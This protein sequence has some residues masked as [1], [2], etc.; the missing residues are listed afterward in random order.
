MRAFTRAALA[1]TAVVALSGGLLQQAVAADVDD[2]TVRVR[3][4]RDSDSNG[5]WDRLKEI[6]VSSITVELTDVD[7]NVRTARTGPDGVAV[8]PPS[9]NLFEGKYYVRLRL[10]NGTFLHD[11]FAATGGLAAQGTIVDVRD[12]EDAEITMGVWNPAD[13]CQD[14]PELSTPCQVAANKDGDVRTTVRFPFS[15]RGDSTSQNN[16]T[17]LATRDDTGNTY[18]LAY[19]REQRRIFA[20]AYAK[21]HTV[22][23]P[24]GTGG[25]YVTPRAG[26]ATTL[27]ATVPNAGNTAH[28]DPVRFDGEFVAAVGKESLGDIEI[29]EDNKEL[30]VVNLNDRQLYTY[31]AD[32]PTATA[33]IDVVP[34]PNPGCRAAGDWRPFGLGVRDGVVYVGGVCSGESTQN[35]ADMEAVVWT[36]SPQTNTFGASPVLRKILN[37]P[38]GQASSA[39]PGSNV[40]NPWL[41]NASAFPQQIVSRPEPM[42]SD[43]E[44]ESNGD[45]ILGFRDRFADMTG[46]E[47]PHPNPAFQGRL[48]TTHSG[49]D[50]NRAC[51][52]AN[53][54]FDW[55]GTGNC[56]NNAPTQPNGGQPAN[57]VEF[58]P[59]DFI[60]TLEHLE[61]AQGA[62]ALS[63]REQRVASTMLDPG[64]QYFT[65]GT[66]YFDRLTGS[67]GSDPNQQGF[68]IQYLNA[69]QDGGFG[70]ANGL[71]DLELLCDEP[72]VQIG[73]RVWWDRNQGGGQ[74]VEVDEPGIPG[75][76]VQLLT[77]DGTLLAT[78][79]TG[80]DG[81]YY[82]GPQHGLRPN[83][84]YKIRFDKST[85]DTGVINPRR[86]PAA[87]SL[88]WS[89]QNAAGAAG[90][91]DSDP[92]PDG[93]ANAR[94]ATV[95][96]TTGPPGT[97]D[98]T[99][100]AGLFVQRL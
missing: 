67:R 78:T 14:N 21:R 32:Q 52:K 36:Y 6:G 99:I 20:G 89:P 37:F 43:I 39:V 34:I 75:V 31:D 51:R 50:L 35:R 93:P 1:M 28:N 38:R 17:T 40:W 62:I 42:L 96:I 41:P 44:V 88:V 66:G 81:T 15:A 98:H 90:D 33:P 30:Y 61:T 72:A 27:F 19:H 68:T 3:V 49:G 45:L 76:T 86:P 9:A 73:N 58:Y 24:A 5:F 57:V 87:S 16:V 46:Y 55:E 7:G 91:L 82:F 25:I 53:G 11:S 64:G 71:G 56:P 80:A 23:G 10:P 92:S 69:H 63:L 22:Y 48:W 74:S 26:G 29:S 4:I 59:G 60:T 100:D 85:A 77:A 12:G 97:V 84:S 18:G 2:G 8:F 95:D 79:T 13:Y 47:M 65:G 94:T 54:T 83:T 70:K